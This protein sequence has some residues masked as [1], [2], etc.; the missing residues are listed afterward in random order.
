VLCWDELQDEAHRRPLANC[1]H[2][3][4][5]RRGAELRARGGPES[6]AWRTQ[7]SPS[8][9]LGFLRLDPPKDPRAW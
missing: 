9:D 4:M 8:P 7:G 5:L 6:L 1:W 3:R 2:A